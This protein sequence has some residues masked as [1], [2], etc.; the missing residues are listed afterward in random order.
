MATS[1]RSKTELFA[2]KRDL[3][4][5]LPEDVKERIL[6]LLST[7]DA[8]TTAL[9]S[10]HWNHVWL[11]HGR[12]VFDKDFFQC[13]SSKGKADKAIDLVNI[14]NN[15]L[16]LRDGPIK[17]FS[18]HMNNRD[19]KPQQIDLDRWCHF[20]SRNGVQE[21]T[22][23]AV[24]GEYKLPSSIV[25]CPTI[26]QLILNGFILDLPINACCIFPRVTSL[27]LDGVEFGSTFIILALLDTFPEFPIERK[28]PMLQPNIIPVPREQ[29]SYGSVSSGLGLGPLIVYSLVQFRMLGKR[30]SES[31]SHQ[32]GVWVLLRAWTHEW[33]G[34][35]WSPN[36]RNP[37]KCKEVV[38]AEHEANGD[39]GEARRC[40]GGRRRPWRRARRKHRAGE[41]QMTDEVGWRTAAN[42]AMGETRMVEEVG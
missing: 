12:L 40:G 25:S 27:V 4:S 26:E 36:A 30:D 20:L 6:E 13:V 32:Y 37:T 15:I 5:E 34:A 11:R 28:P 23:L 9:L 24:C 42:L 38:D 7:R 33:P 19:L 16:L 17:K 39:G 22:L 29:G 35:S 3:I 18:L 21:L 1:P 8:T 31:K 10:S 14:I 41:T 2:R